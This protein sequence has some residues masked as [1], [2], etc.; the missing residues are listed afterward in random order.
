MQP[1]IANH[2]AIVDYG[3]DGPR[4]PVAPTDRAAAANAKAK[5]KAA[6]TTTTTTTTSA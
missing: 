4:E 2:R 5:A 3:G 6:A 1:V